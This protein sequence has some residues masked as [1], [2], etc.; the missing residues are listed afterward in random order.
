MKR[1]VLLVEGSG[2]VAAAPSLVGELLTRLPDDL[3]G[4][5]F[6]DNAPMKVGGVHQITGKRQSELVRHL[7][8]A[9]KRSKLGA[10]ILMLDGDADRVEGTPFCA[11]EVARNIAQ[12]ATEAGAGATFSFASVF[13]RQEYE[14]LLIAVAGQLPGLKSEVKL[15]S[16]PELAPRDA[17]GWLHAGLVDGYNPIDHQLELTRAVKDWAPVRLLRCFRRLEHALVELATAVS[18]GKHVV[19]PL[20]PAA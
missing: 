9:N 13:L 12:R 7:G 10:A 5:L 8:N 11:V 18:T 4:Q 1:M 15:P 17:K 2:D 19:S 14:S 20:T 6:L 16:D 3:Q